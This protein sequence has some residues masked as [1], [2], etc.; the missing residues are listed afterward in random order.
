MDAKA[1]FELTAQVRDAQKSYFNTP[2]AA[3]RQKQD[4]LQLSKRLE[5]QLDAEIKR[6]RD[7]MAR[8]QFKK[9]NPTLPG[10]DFDE[11]LLNRQEP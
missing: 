7:I 1:F 6:V 8:E 4:Y 11:D 9:Q 3:Y 2:A 10:F 5:G